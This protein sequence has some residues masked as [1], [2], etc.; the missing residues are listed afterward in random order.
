MKNASHSQAF[1][2]LDEHWSVVDK[3]SLGGRHLDHIQRKP[4]H[5]HIGLAKV[6]KGRGNERVH[7]TIQVEL[8]N[9]IGKP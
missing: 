8:A 6:N 9:P 4:E 3:D 2:N 5:I 1:R 7:Q